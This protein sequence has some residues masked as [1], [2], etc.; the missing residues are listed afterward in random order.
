MHILNG[1]RELEHLV[2]LP[3]IA[4]ASDLDGTL[5]HFHDDL[6]AVRLL[7]EASL[8]LTQL[9]SL[10]DVVLALVSGRSLAMLQQIASPPPT[11]ILIGSH[12]AEVSNPISGYQ[13]DALLSGEEA[14]LLAKVTA[15]L[16]D[17]ASQFPGVYVETKP[18]A[19]AL[20]T[21]RVNSV[22]GEEARQAAL[23]GPG[24]WSKVEMTLGHEVVEL[25]V[26]KVDKGSALLESLVDMNV[27]AIFYM[28]DDRTDED[29]FRLLAPHPSNLTI[30]IGS[31]STLAK[32]RLPD[33]PSAAGLLLT[34]AKLRAAAYP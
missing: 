21:R 30:K 27:D 13:H 19:A 22:H 20:H 33:P 5:A 8:A 9:A 11:A 2:S 26:K 4:V 28:G 34:L 14:R 10:Q 12:G 24:R 6:E 32:H 16:S 15:A 17:I 29:V 18:T 3:R 31:G 7:P 25:K 1:G 23:S